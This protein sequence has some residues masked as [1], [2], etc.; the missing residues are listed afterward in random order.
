[1]GETILKKYVPGPGK[2]ELSRMTIDVPSITI[3][4]RIEDKGQ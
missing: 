4:G 3:K 2:Y 1:L